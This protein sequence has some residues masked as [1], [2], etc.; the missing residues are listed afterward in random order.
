M[1]R[2]Y[3]FMPAMMM[4]LTGY[5][6]GQD[7]PA[8]TKPAAA[9]EEAGAM[10]VTVV[11]VTGQVR[12]LVPGV[13]GQ[14]DR[15]V[16]VKAGEK[17][18][19]LTV[20]HTGFRSKAVLRFADRGEVTVHRG[21]KVGI[22]EFRKQGNMVK[23]RLGLKYG[24]MRA[25]VDSSRG[26]NDMQVRTAVATLSVR[27]TALVIGNSERGLGLRMQEGSGRAG[28][29]NRTR[30]VVAGEFTDTQLTPPIVVAKQRFH[31]ALGDFF[32][33]SRTERRSLINNTPTL[34]PTTPTG[35]RPIDAVIAPTVPQASVRPPQDHI[36][37]GM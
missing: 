9:P 18:G 21:T 10:Q 13:E 24:M 25:K 2:H 30:N 15:W 35:G 1:Y 6:L 8:A 16:P 34:N 36:T 32:G 3:A 12:K 7:T 33:L 22:A 27:G 26:P 5:A 28:A 23:T 20:I 31:T 17:L 4:A 37:I 29:G 11:S 14:K 19:E